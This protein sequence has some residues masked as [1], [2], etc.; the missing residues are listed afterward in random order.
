MKNALTLSI[1]AAMPVLLLQ[2]WLKILQL[3]NPILLE[4]YLVDVVVV[5]PSTK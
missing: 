4:D 1:F 5:V 2:K 3:I